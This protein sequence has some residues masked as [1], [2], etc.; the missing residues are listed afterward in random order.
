MSTSYPKIAKIA[1]L[2]FSA[3]SCKCFRKKTQKTHKKTLFFTFF[4]RALAYVRKKQYLCVTFQGWKKYPRR[5]GVHI[6]TLTDT[7]RRRCSACLP[8]R[9]SACRFGAHTCTKGLQ[10]HCRAAWVLCRLGRARKPAAVACCPVFRSTWGGS[11]RRK[12]VF[13]V[14][15]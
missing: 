8:F 13:F 7:S 1:I 5:K 15:G 4:L 6:E 14:V 11:P 2:R 9:L 12:M 3:H 10:T